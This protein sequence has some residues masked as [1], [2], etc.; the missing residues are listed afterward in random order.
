MAAITKTSG[1]GGAT[2]SPGPAGPTGPLRSVASHAALKTTTAPTNSGDIIAVQGATSATDG[3]AGQFKWVTGT[4]PAADDIFTIWH[5]TDATGSFQRVWDGK[6]ANLGWA[7]LAAGATSSALQTAVTAMTGLNVQLDKLYTGLT[8]A[9]TVPAGTRLHATVG[10]Y[11]F[12][13]NGTVAQLLQLGTGC[14]VENLELDG[15]VTS[16][17]RYVPFSISGTIQL[18]T[19]SVVK[20]CRIK[21]SAQCAIAGYNKTGIVI[22]NVTIDAP[23]SVAI[24][25]QVCT[26]LRLVNVTINNPMHDGI[27]IHTRDGTITNTQGYKVYLRDCKIDYS[28]VTLTTSAATLAIEFWGGQTTWQNNP[29]LS[30]IDIA[31]P[32]SV[33]TGGWWAISLDTVYGGL[34]DDCRIDGGPSGAIIGLEAAGCRYTVFRDCFVKRFKQTGL[35]I[36]QSRSTGI[37]AE[38]CTFRDSTVF[39]GSYGIQAVT[40]TGHKFDRCIFRD[41]GEAGIFLNGNEIGNYTTITNNSFYIS[42]TTTGQI[43]GIKTSGTVRYLTIAHNYF[44]PLLDPGETGSTQNLT[45]GDFDNIQSSVFRDN[46]LNGQKAD[47]SGSGYSAFNT[48]GGSGGNLF[49]GT[50]SLNNTGPGATSFSAS[51]AASVFENN[52]AAVTYRTTG[53]VDILVGKN[54]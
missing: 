24:F 35:S 2:G 33:G 8:T 15:G 22:E 4:R 28:N 34:V 12:K 48:Y 54:S 52:F 45:A 37:V 9:L 25:T 21:N 32:A 31:G 44:G 47:A 50:R 29:H 6:N 5:N 16:A 49:A 20:N 14:T 10:G 27:K 30:G 42:Q 13:G 18:N 53:T 3:A 7:A 17:A 23:Q 41:A 40:G 36:S 38:G 43:K 1:G 26:D 19:G 11:G 46:T 39:T 51:G